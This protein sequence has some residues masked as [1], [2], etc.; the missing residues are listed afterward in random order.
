MMESAKPEADMR[1]QS[2]AAPADRDRPAH[3]SAEP[4]AEMKGP[5]NGGLAD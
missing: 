4:D 5:A 3:F 1:P 2:A